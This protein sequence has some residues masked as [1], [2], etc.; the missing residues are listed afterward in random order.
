MAATSGPNTKL[1]REK[2]KIDP[3]LVKEWSDLTSYSQR[4]LAKKRPIPTS[5]PAAQV[6]DALILR[7]TAQ[8]LESLD[9]SCTNGALNMIGLLAEQ[10]MAH[11]IEELHRIAAIQRRTKPNLHDIAFLFTEEGIHTGELELEIERSKRAGLRSMPVVFTSQ[12]GIDEPSSAEQ[13]EEWNNQQKHLTLVTPTARSATELQYI[14]SWLPPLPAD[15]T[16]RA[17]PNYTKRETSPRAVRERIL[18]EGRVVEEALRRLGG[19]GNVSDNSKYQALLNDAEQQLAA[20]ARRLNNK[21]R[22]DIVALAQTRKKKA[23]HPIILHI[24][25]KGKA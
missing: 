10:Y 8:L 25:K 18:E 13:F 23:I 24:G 2:T 6:A 19:L 15:H 7:P 20:E 22:F 5:S 9:V 12:S 4:Q 1:T 11:L 21:K 17:T 16:Y 3:T 14:P